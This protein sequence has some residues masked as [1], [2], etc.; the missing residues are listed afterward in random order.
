VLSDPPPTDTVPE[1]RTHLITELGPAAGSEFQTIQ[2]LLDL[3]TCD[4]ADLIAAPFGCTSRGKRQSG[5][6]SHPVGLAAWL[7]DVQ[8]TPYGG[9]SVAQLIARVGAWARETDECRP[10]RRGHT[11]RRDSW[12]D[13]LLPAGP[14][15][16]VLV[17]RY[18]ST[19][20]NRSEIQRETMNYAIH[21]KSSLFFIRISG[22]QLGT[23]SAT[24]NPFRDC[25]QL[26]NQNNYGSK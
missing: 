4:V 12:S 10:Y 22:T 11:S 15:R 5:R 18:R 25:T 6:S 14:T 20:D 8:A 2:P 16:F 7:T 23:M 3:D 24:I 13:S 21:R 9:E 26:V 17:P 1:D 19:F